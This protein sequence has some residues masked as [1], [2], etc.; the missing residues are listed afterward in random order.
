L[1]KN[2]FEIEEKIEGILKKNL[3]MEDKNGELIYNPLNLKKP[4]KRS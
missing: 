1:R 3:M 4:E 2:E